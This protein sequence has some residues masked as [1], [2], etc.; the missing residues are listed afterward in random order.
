VVAAAA[1]L[2]MMVMLMRQLLS[3]ASDTA[4][5]SRQ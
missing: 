2:Q 3:E 4:W 1:L 5:Q